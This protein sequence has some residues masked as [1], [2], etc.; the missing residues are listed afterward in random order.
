MA[1]KIKKIVYEEKDN[2]SVDIEFRPSEDSFTMDFAYDT[3]GRVARIIRN[4]TD[5]NN[6]K[7]NITYKFNYDVVGEIQ[8]EE[9]E[10]EQG[11]DYTETT[12][13]VVEL[14][15][16]GN[17]T[18]VQKI[19]H[20]CPMVEFRYTDDV[21]LG[22]IVSYEYDAEK[23]QDI[24]GYE[25]GLLRKY[26]YI[27]RYGD[28]EEYTF[29]ESYYTQKYPN[30]GMIDMLGYISDGND[31]DF[32]FYIG[33]LSKTSD[34]FVETM[35]NDDDEAMNVL[36]GYPAEDN[37]KTKTYLTVEFADSKIKCE[38]DTD[39]NLTKVEKSIAYEVIKKSY[40]IKV[41]TDQKPVGVKDGIPYYPG[42][43]IYG[44]DKKIKDGTDYETYTISY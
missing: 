38:Y 16:R 1:K 6:D 27:S 44:P 41:Y 7:T 24:F 5:Y 29:S 31:Y 15:D 11:R 19:G 43:C 30:N 39:D 18:K 36:G 10:K 4:E 8:V 21:R 25:N 20:I 33:R 17:A 34:Y 42:D 40:T 22:K 12:N 26:S 23:G 35:L 2:S 37:E 32:L 9:I 28:N 14:D 3:D 13:Y